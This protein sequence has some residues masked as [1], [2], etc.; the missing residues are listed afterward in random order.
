MQEKHD[1]S[2]AVL[3]LHKSLKRRFGSAPVIHPPGT[4]YARNASVAKSWLGTMVTP[5]AASAR[6]LS[7]VDR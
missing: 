4:P 3:L 7:Y 2:A 6:S 5:D 1:E